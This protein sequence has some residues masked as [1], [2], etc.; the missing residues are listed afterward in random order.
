MRVHH[1]NCIS[2]CPLGGRLMD[3]G[4][5]S[6][7]ERAHLTNHCLL[8][9]DN[10]QLILVDTGFGLKE[11]NNP[12]GRLSEFFLKLNSPDLREEMTAFRQIQKLGFD[13]SDVRHILLTHLDFDHAGGLDDFPGAKVHMLHSEKRNAVLQKTWLDRQ[14]FR[15]QQWSTMQNWVTYQPGEG[16]NWFGFGKVQSLEGIS[17]DI[18]MIPLIGHTLGHAG[19][20]VKVKGGWLLN[21]GDAYFYNEEMN[22]ENPHCT[23][24][25]TFYQKMMDK[26][27]KSRVWN[28]ARLRELIFS[29]SDEVKVFCAHDKMEFEKCAGRDAE[30]PIEKWSGLSLSEERILNYSLN[31]DF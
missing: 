21:A 15:P 10:N 19:I 12:H 11:V 18:A 5:E 8:I 14:R 17:N 25:L 23:P 24:G 2:S 22:Y 9:E 30:T 29:H 16:T 28:Q 26:D 27:H 13:P 3:G 1:L 4:A 20:A 6:L 31:P 7:L